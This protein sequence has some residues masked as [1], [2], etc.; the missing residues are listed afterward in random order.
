MKYLLGGYYGMRNVGDDVLLYVTL[1]ETARVDARASFTVISDLDELT[2]PGVPVRTDPGGRRLENVRQ[3]LR[4]DVWLFG[5]GGLLQDGSP[6]AVGYLQRLARAARLIK[7]LGRRMVLL[8]I[9]VGPLTTDAGR[10]AAGRL[11]GQADLVT[12][13]DDESRHLAVDLAP[14]VDVTVTADLAFLLP[15]HVPVSDETSSDHPVLGISLLPHARSL[16]RDAADDDRA[17]TNLAHALGEALRRHPEWRVTLFEFFA[18]RSYGDAHV[19][20]RVERELGDPAR[21]SYRPYTGDFVAL[22]AEMRTCR[23]FIG[24]R[25]H[26]CLLAHVANVPC[27]MLAYHAKSESLALRLGLHADAVV[28]LPMLYEPQALASRF[29]DLLTDHAKFRPTRGLQALSAAAERNFSLLSACLM[30]AR[31]RRPQGKKA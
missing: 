21:V 9:G 3:M 10:T 24:M 20:R 15:K 25:F 16:G 5:G 18:N 14:D 28:P 1:G 17:A 22:Y 23:A 12:V 26:A 31:A 7:L 27:L 2:P 19:L 30:G 29:D 11:L 8:G 13:R 4:H 6:R